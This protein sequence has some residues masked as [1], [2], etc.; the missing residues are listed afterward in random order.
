MRSTLCVLLAAASS[1]SAAY[2]PSGFT[3]R[4]APQLRRRIHLLCAAQPADAT[5]AAAPAGLE[6]AASE[7]ELLGCRPG[8][9]RDKLAKQEFRL[10]RLIQRTPGL[11]PIALGVHYSLLPKVITPLLA[12]IVWI[13]SLPAGASL[14]TFVCAGDLVNTVIKWGIQRPRPRWY[15]GSSEQGLAAQCGAWE[16]DLSFPSAHTQ[17]FSGLAFCASAMHGVS[18]LPALAFGVVIALTRNFLSV[19]WPTDTLTG[20]VVGGGLGML[21][22]AHDP[23]AAL[24]AARSPALSIAAAT[25]L[26]GGLLL[27]MLLMRAIVPPPSAITRQAWYANALSSLP[28]DERQSTSID[29]EKMLKPRSLRSKIPMITTVWCTVAAT[30]FY[31]SALPTAVL[32]PMGGPVARFAHAAVGV[33]GLF[34]VALL[35][36]AVGKLKL[37][38]FGGRWRS[39]SHESWALSAKAALKCLTYVGICSWVFLLSQICAR[40]LLGRLGVI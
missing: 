29:P 24:V 18:M 26:A 40:A 4:V 7:C 9:F 27:L 6:V 16:V 2:I 3:S 39:G 34:A 23:Y 17:F 38:R 31:P 37:G 14:I 19:H 13:I 22:G 28:P 20:L 36:T 8:G 1:A 32:E 12:L 30:A 33:S 15:A 10:L 5:M 25:G 11:L 21:W 35:K